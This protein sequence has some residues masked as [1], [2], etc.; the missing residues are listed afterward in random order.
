MV[1]GM[2]VILVVDRMNALRTDKP[3]PIRH[4][5]DLFF[6]KNRVRLRSRQLGM[7]SNCGR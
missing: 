6:K 2:V 4:G 5:I 7:P 1:F 3:S